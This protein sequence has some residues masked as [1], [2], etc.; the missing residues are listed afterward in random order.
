MGALEG[1][2]VQVFAMGQ[3]STTGS[4]T[5]NVNT[6]EQP[7]P[8]SYWKYATRVLS[9]PSGLAC[10]F[11]YGI[12]GGMKL[13]NW[14]HETTQYNSHAI[15]TART[16]GEIGGIIYGCSV[17][18]AVVQTGARAY[19]AAFNASGGDPM[20]AAV[21]KIKRSFGRVNGLFW[22]TAHAPFSCIYWVCEASGHAYNNRNRG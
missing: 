4:T 22:A 19:T 18:L 15:E 13:S 1:S 20:A 3:G 10:I 11:G 9:I 7:K 8:T 16:V 14:M 6:D 17:F 5:L 12:E 2:N 21:S